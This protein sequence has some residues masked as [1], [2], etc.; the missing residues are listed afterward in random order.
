MTMRWLTAA[1]IL[2]LGIGTA[3]ADIRINESRYVNGKL[4]VTG[5]TAPDRTVTLD[6]K[7][8]T[9]S[10]GDGD[11]KFTVDKYKPADCMSDIRS[12]AD[13]Y[14]AVIAGC[15]GAITEPGAVVT[16]GKPA[17]HM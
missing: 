2:L 17:K 14:S 8:K 12:G 7:Y 11:F 13:V 6:K 4:I 1:L 3:C 15:F 9:K 16:S 10:D 5:Q